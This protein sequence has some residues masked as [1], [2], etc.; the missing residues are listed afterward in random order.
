MAG[1]SVSPRDG[2]TV[3]S[4]EIT[5]ARNT[6]ITGLTL[7]APAGTDLRATDRV[8]VRGVLYDVD[9]QPGWFGSP[10]TGS[11]GPVVAVLEV[12]TG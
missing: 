2:N 6:V 9:G 12:V 4:N 3:G 1:C 8:R 7:Y 5:Q 10:F 11:A